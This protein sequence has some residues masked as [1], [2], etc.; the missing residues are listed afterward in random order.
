MAT[1]SSLGI[2]TSGLNVADIVSQLVALEKKPL[3]NLK[4]KAT[5]TQTKITTMGQIKSLVDTL[6]T[7]V[8]KLTS[9]TGWNAVSASSSGDAVSAS[10]VGGTQPT[11]FQFEVSNLAKSQST[12]SASISPVGSL[13]GE[14]TLTL[15]LGTWSGGA[16]AGTFAP[17]SAAAVDISITATD[18]VASIASKIN[19]ANAGVT[20]TVLNDGSGERLL[21][22]GKNVGAASG[23]NLSVT[24]TDGNNTDASGLSR[25]VNGISV[26]REAEDAAAKINGI[27]VTSTTNTFTNVVSGVTLT[28]NKTN[29]G[30][31]VTVTVSQDTSAMKSNIEAFVKAYNDVNSVLNEATK[32][33]Q[34]AEV[35]GLFQGD[36][37]MVALQSAL[38]T[39]L[40]TVNTSGGSGAVYTTLS[41][42]GVRI[43]KPIIGSN[44]VEGGGALEIDS[45]VLT[46]ALANSDTMKALFTSTDSN[47]APGL[48]VK[49]KSVTTALLSSTGFFERK[50]DSLERELTS[51]QEQQDKVNARASAVEAQLTRRYTAL[52]T[53]M[54]QLNSLS[55][56]LEQ[57]ISQWN[58]S[59]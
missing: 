17:G 15:Q 10:A 41:S 13:V 4:L 29:V 11:S 5:A 44:S 54:S 1:I 23:F 47:G 3:D 19:G 8:G 46:A 48:A 53:Q 49:I 16:F 52:D 14:G 59:K 2:G 28:A 43:T 25:L 12:S 21:L 31:P 56:Y 58:K 57:Q 34:S 30:S 24:D 40:Q 50:N 35:G 27:S 9:V 22:T 33:D 6:N 18:T 36:S 39:A 51:N 7:A 26:T 45:T 38:R 37:T 32:Y 55:T 42:V 20:A